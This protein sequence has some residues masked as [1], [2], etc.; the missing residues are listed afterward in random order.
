ME[1]IVKLEKTIPE[2]LNTYLDQITND[3]SADSNYSLNELKSN[4][5]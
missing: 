3:G 1:E 4:I 2:V 5:N